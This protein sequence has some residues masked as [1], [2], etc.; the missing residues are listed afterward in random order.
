MLID[1]VG[2]THACLVPV[3]A[4]NA[5]RLRNNVVIGLTQWMKWHNASA[6]AATVDYMYIFLLNADCARPG[7]GMK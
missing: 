5:L 6:S 1:S 4:L 7:S 2:R 3:S